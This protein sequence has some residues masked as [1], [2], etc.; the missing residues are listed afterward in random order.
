M[1]TIARR[2]TVFMLS[3]IL[4]L[5]TVT[6]CLA[7]GRTGAGGRSGGAGSGGAGGMGFFDGLDAFGNTVGTI[8]CILNVGS[9]LANADWSDPVA[10]CLDLVDSIFGTSFGGDP[11]MDKLDSIYNDVSEIK[12]TTAEIQQSVDYLVQNSI[13]VNQ[14]LSVSNGSLRT[15]NSQLKRQTQMLCDISTSIKA[16]ND[17]MSQSFVDLRNLVNDNTSEIKSVVYTST[18]EIEKSTQLN[19]ALNSYVSE[20]SK[21]Y[22]Y[23]NNILESLS[24]MQDDYT[25]FYN[26]IMK[27]DNGVEIIEALNKITLQEDSVSSCISSI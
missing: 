27:L 25:T 14:Q 19:N 1:K 12:Q 11:M 16:M 6:P 21:L 5:S 2:V 17:E 10:V 4:V 15:I 18:V 24:I 26:A 9:T 7:A 8:G 13:Y 3:M 20:Y 23:E 22:T